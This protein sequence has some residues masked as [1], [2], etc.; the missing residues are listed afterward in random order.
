MDIEAR[1]LQFGYTHD[2]N[3][4][5]LLNDGVDFGALFFIEDAS[6]QK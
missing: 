6:K 2:N 3:T 1:L 4:Y 5:V